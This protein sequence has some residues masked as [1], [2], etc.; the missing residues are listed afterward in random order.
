MSEAQLGLARACTGGREAFPAP[1]RE[2]FV[3]AGRRSGKSRIAALIACYEAAFIDHTPRLAPGEVATVAVI[4]ADM[5]QART[6]FRYIRATIR[7]SPMLASLITGERALAL[8][9]GQVAIE[10]MAASVSG[11]RSYTFA[12]V[13]CDELAFWPTSA[14]CAQPHVEILS[15][16][17]PGLG[18]AG[19]Q[20]AL[21]QHAVPAIG[22][23]YEAF[24]AGYGQETQTGGPV[25]VWKAPTLVMHPGLE[26]IVAAETARVP[27]AAAAE[28]QAEWRS[29]LQALL[30]PELVDGATCPG[31]RELP[32][33]RGVSYEAFCDPSG[34]RHDAMTLGV[35][36][37]ENGTVVLDLL[38]VVKPPFS[39]DA[40]VLA[41]LLAPYGLRSVVGDRYAGEWPIERFAAHGIT[42][43]ASER[44]KSEIYAG[45][46]PLFTGDTVR[47]LEHPQLRHE[48]LGLERRAARSGKDSIDHRPGSHDDAANAWAGALV[49]AEAGAGAV[50]EVVVSHHGE[51]IAEK[52]AREDV[53]GM[54]S[55]SDEQRFYEGRLGG[56]SIFGDEGRRRS[57]V[58]TI[59]AGP[60]G[61]PTW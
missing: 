30:T 15:A 57:D 31:R 40:V 48:L 37:S 2:G 23:L 27:A 53:P 20:A 11:T 47:L 44:T 38:E 16:I 24:R 39:P 19:R 13:I 18:D 28:W 61:S 7:R 8:D 32:P 3:I 12:A 58:W 9:L 43:T 45:M 49:L 41:A 51:S 25:L 29:D 10:V 54:S 21:H 33:E 46:L 1:S 52:L 59:G 26:K 34:G 4:A 35:A 14:E 5:K 36:H 42:Y 22:A 17:R 50:G 6:V 56:G 60:R 55:D